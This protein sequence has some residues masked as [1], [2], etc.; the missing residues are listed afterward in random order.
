MACCLTLS[1]S[2]TTSLSRHDTTFFARVAAVFLRCQV[3][4]AS[5]CRHSYSSRAW[6][7]CTACNYPTPLHIRTCW[8]ARYAQDE[9]VVPPRQALYT[10]G[11][12][13]R[14]VFGSFFFV[15]FVFFR[16]FFFFV[17]LFLARA[18][19]PTTVSRDRSAVRAAS[20]RW[21]AVR[22]VTASGVERCR[23][24]EVPAAATTWVVVRGM[25]RQVSGHRRR[26]HV[27]RAT[28]AGIPRRVLQGQRGRERSAHGM[29]MSRRRMRMHNV[30]VVAGST[31]MY[32]MVRHLVHG[33]VLARPAHLVHFGV[34]LQVGLDREPPST[35][36][37]LAHKRSLAG[38]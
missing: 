32:P 2:G 35:R 33:A 7:S 11:R 10:L 28:S 34:S 25:T 26:M 27:P 36:W 20:W 16:F 38:I 21:V 37:L 15:K 6:Q 13:W 30:L 3:P 18:G 23:P 8:C 12:P 19:A 17:P 14:T 4:P 24:I 29:M 1:L 22:V 5:Y 9:Q 31:A